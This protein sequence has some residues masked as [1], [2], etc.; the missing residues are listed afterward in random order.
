MA[1]SSALEAP[2]IESVM[3]NY[4]GGE[5]VASKTKE[6]V[7]VLNPATLEVITRVP[8]STTDEVDQAVKA[9]HEAFAEWRE[10]P[11]AQRVR[12]LF[13]LR[14]LL[15]DNY[16]DLA[17]L[18]TLEHGK[19]IDEARGEMRRTVENL[20][21][22]AGIPSLMMGYNLEDGAAANIDEEVIRHPLG[23][24][25]AICPFNF[26]G[27][28]PFWFWPYAV[29]CGNTHIVKPS[30][31]TPVSITKIFELID[32]AG[33]PPGVV[34][35]V[36]GGKDA[37]N[38][39]IEHP[40]VQGISF[41]GSTPVAKHVYAASAAAGKRAQCQGGAKN[42]LV[43]MPDA[44]LERSV[45]NLVSSFFGTAGQRCLAGSVLVAV[46]DV[47][48][49]LV[50]QFTAAAARITVGNG[51]DESIGMGPVIS[52][53]SLKRVLGFIEEAEKDGAKLL[54][55]G[56]K[57]PVQGN[58]PGYFVGPTVVDNV[59]PSMRIAREEVFGPVACIMRVKT[60]DEALDLI[61]DVPFGNAASIYTSSGGAAREFRYRVQAGNVG[62]NV[63]IAAPMAYFPFG[64]A[65]D[66]F[67][68]VMHGQGRDGIDF[69]TDRKVVITRWL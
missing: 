9:A 22:A 35:M 32:E 54:L 48:D 64:G 67:F 57:T 7:D 27:M 46:G 59:K 3:R 65:K 58:L 69:F 15:E 28:V 29:A 18:M 55:D 53:A 10:T 13:R 33:F 16:E 61:H 17:R 62:V 2:K 52:D 50:E 41:V 12:P 11:P 24:F 63:G 34:N 19:I 66:S 4:I 21:V 14:T 1:K 39:L 44:N 25:A 60:M 23:V 47:A 45:P 20:E 6:L 51:L 31:L 40:Q 30:P 36:H 68:G 56:R 42:F 43:V 38:R 26:P 49:S 5:W 37:A 8:E